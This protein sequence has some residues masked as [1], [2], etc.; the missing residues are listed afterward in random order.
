[1]G[2]S[3][4]ARYVRPQHPDKTIFELLR[5]SDDPLLPKVMAATVEVC[6]DCSGSCVPFDNSVTTNISNGQILR[7]TGLNAPPG[8]TVVR[9]GYY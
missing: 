4:D 1:M 8:A 2:D 3:P 9:F 7:I 6:S 5:Q